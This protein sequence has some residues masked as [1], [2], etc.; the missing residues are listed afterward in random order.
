MTNK[1]QPQLPDGLINL[2]RQAEEFTASMTQTQQKILDD[3]NHKK[4]VQYRNDALKKRSKRKGKR[5]PTEEDG[6]SSELEQPNYHLISQPPS[7]QFGKL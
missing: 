5:D 6:P 2:L 1:P 7:M 4:A 3:D